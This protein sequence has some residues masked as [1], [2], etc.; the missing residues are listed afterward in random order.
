MNLNKKITLFAAILA[1]VLLVTLTLLSLYSFRQYSI[2]TA[3]ERVRTAAEIVRVNLT[4]RKS[5]V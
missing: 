2:V 1:G 4:D 3:K 5:V